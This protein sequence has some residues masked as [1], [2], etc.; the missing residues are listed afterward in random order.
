MLYG[1]YIWIYMDGCNVAYFRYIYILGLIFAL[2]TEFFSR[3][4]V[5]FGFTGQPHNK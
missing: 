3:N 2:L 1:I 4:S 5:Q